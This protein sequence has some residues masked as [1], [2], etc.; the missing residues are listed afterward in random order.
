MKETLH[1]GQ[2]VRL[3]RENGWEFVERTIPT[4]IVLIVAVTEDDRVLLLE[5]FRPPVGRPTIELPAGLAGDIPGHRDENMA[6]AAR[7]ELLEET[8]YRATDM[9]CL[10]EGP[11]SPGI[12]SEVSGT[13][14]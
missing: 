13:P 7:R 11:P 9:V 12:S 6:T 1:E 5:Q 2:Y 14:R 4:G 10:T 3:V 8:G